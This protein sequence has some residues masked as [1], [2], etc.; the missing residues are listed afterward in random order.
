MDLVQ[1]KGRARI[2]EK[3]DRFLA[4][5]EW[6]NLFPNALSKNCGFF[7]S[8]HRAI[9]LSLNHKIW[10]AK[11]AQ[12]LQFMFEN[13]WTKEEDFADNVGVFWESTR[14][15]QTL[16]KKFT[17]CGKLI[18]S[19]VE[20]RVG[21]TKNKIDKLTKKIN[22]VQDDDREGENTIVLQRKLEKLLLQEE[23]HWQQRAK[24][25]LV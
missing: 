5:R 16:Q 17:T 14:N 20:Q 13:K 12:K 15:I 11:E 9:E 2:K 25:I 18:S 4:N 3:L 7:D 19:W 21:N 1:R 22:R 6:S 8:N 23:A 10:V 24:K